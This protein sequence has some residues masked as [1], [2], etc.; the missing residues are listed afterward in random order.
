MPVSSRLLAKA[1]PTGS[2]GVISGITHLGD[3]QELHN[4]NFSQREKRGEEK[5]AALQTLRMATSP[6]AIICAYG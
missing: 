4:R 6:K 2:G 1:E 5:A 3:R